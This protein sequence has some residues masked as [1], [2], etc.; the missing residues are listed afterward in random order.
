[1]PAQETRKS[2]AMLDW[3]ENS[4]G[5][6]DLFSIEDFVDVKINNKQPDV[7]FEDMEEIDAA[8]EAVRKGKWDEFVAARP[9]MNGNAI[10]PEEKPQVQPEIKPQPASP[11]SPVE[12]QPVMSLYDL[13]GF[14]EEERNQSNTGKLKKKKNVSK[15][16]NP[17]QLNL[18]SQSQVETVKNSTNNTGTNHARANFMPAY[19]VFDARKEEMEKQLRELEKPS[20][21][22]GILQQHHKQGSL[23]A[24]QNGQ[25]GFLKERYHDDAVFKSLELNPLQ[26]QKAKL[27][28][29]IRDAYHSLYNY[30]AKELKENADLRQSLNLHYDTFVKRYGNLNDKNSLDLIKMDAGGQEILLTSSMR[31]PTQESGFSSSNS[32]LIV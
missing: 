22:S 28:I 18:F 11:A 8:V 6:D 5:F 14:S 15:Q 27:Y 20:P 25:I 23:V 29:E 26:E 1:M 12:R 32:G 24:E 9:Y 21:Y 10:K 30:E 17:R 7:S 19:P 16:G 3:E 31:H 4:L 2:T 13:F